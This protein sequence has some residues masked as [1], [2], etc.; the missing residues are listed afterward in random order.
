DLII[1]S[2]AKRTKETARRMADAVGFDKNEIKWVDELYHGL[3]LAYE[4]TLERF[5]AN[6][7]LVFIIGHNPG[8]TQLVNG[9]SQKFQIDNVPACGVA[10]GKVFTDDWNNFRIAEKEVLNF[11]APKII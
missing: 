7:D 9:F 10:L 6:H 8:I 11:D 4:E 5:G 2:P 1:S 3:P